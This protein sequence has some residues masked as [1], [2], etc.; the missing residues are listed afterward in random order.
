MGWF[1][2]LFGKFLPSNSWDGA[3]R[4]QS[5]R[6]RCDFEIE[7]RA[8]NC[9]YLARVVDA[10]PQGLR[11]KVRGPWVAR[12]LK[13]S[14]KVELRYVQPLFEADLDTVG[15][16]I[17]WV[18]REGENMF[19][20]AVGFSD[21]L[22]NLRKSWVKPVLQKYFKS[23]S[24][25]N[26]RKWMRARCNLPGRLQLQGQAQDVKVVDLSS[27]GAR[28]SSI[29]A[30]E[31]GSLVELEFQ[32]ISVRAMVKRCQPDYGVYRLGLAFAPEKE[33]RKKIL[34]LLQKLVAVGRILDG[35]KSTLDP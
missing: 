27:T 30:C 17:R 10:G 15:A 14:Q 3:E 1:E 4:R 2:S 12:V 5:F 26:Q 13:R 20:L 11:L 9:S 28:L 34:T 29:Q 24:R 18:R 8:P 32:G 31:L 33:A 21:T 6:V 25:K 35:G 23:D 19:S 22:E 7:M 16:S